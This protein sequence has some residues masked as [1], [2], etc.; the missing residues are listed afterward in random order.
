MK[1]TK[2]V[3]IYENMREC[4]KVVFKNVDT[5]INYMELNHEIETVIEVKT[6]LYSLRKDLKI[7]VGN[8]L[9]FFKDLNAMNDILVGKAL[10]NNGLYDNDFI[11]T[12]GSDKRTGY[13]DYHFEITQYDFTSHNTGK[14]VISFE[15]SLDQSYL[16]ETIK[17]LTSLIY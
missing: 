7:N 6:E 10:L 13:F 15:R 4:V 8:I 5:R 2:E 17:A 3:I 1:E 9:N 14:D 12:I 16:K 11:L